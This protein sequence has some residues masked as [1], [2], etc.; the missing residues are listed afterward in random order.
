M[1]SGR[2]RVLLFAE[3]VTLAHVARVIALARQLDASRYEVI[4]AC[5]PRAERFL[6]DEPFRQVALSSIP[7]ADF[8][9]ALARG[10]PVYDE[11]TLEAYVNQDLQLIDEIQP[12]LVVGD[13]RLSLSASA[14]LAGVPFL[15]IVNAYWC[16][17]WQG[18]FPL[19]VLPATRWLPLAL[20][21]SVFRV[22]LP[23][24]LARHCVPLNRVRAQRGL[25]SLGSDLRTVYSDA[26]QVLVADAAAMFPL[27]PLP[28]H[29]S[30]IGPLLW[31]PNVKPPSWWHSLPAGRPIV[32]VTLGSSGHVA[33]LPR[34]LTALSTL[35]VTVIV[36]TAGQALNYPLPDG[37]HQADYLPGAEATA[38]ARLLICNGGS[39]TTQ[40]ALLAGVPILGIAA[41][42][43]QFMSMAPVVEQGAGLLL[44]ADRLSELT[45]RTAARSLLEDPD[46]AAASRRLGGILAAGPDAAQVFDQAVERLLS[47]A[48][49][50]QH[51]MSG[52]K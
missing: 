16:S 26:D 36:S 22:A 34:I 42:M 46:A 48:P 5:D 32:Y 1:T 47:G 17:G 39:L 14:R 27:R 18:G 24:A 15:A 41:N 35:P 7:S 44:R 31:S 33:L 9:R 19:P 20:V 25:P 12:D 30:Y 50:T 3:A 8:A 38:R 49:R 51:S 43:D 45:V 37:M 40:Q 28:L 10:A 29:V 4:V 6:K 23:F 11:A 2:L 13:F 52:Q 21:D